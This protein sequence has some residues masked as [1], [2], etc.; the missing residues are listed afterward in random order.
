MPMQ[1]DVSLDPLE[2]FG[3]PPLPAPSRII[4]TRVDGTLTEIEIVLTGGWAGPPPYLDGDVRIKLPAKALPFG[5][6]LMAA[7]DNRRPKA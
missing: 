2:Y 7:W 3:G 1:A 4:E 6:W 5:Q